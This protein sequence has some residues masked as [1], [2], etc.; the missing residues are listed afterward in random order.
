MRL[1][2]VGFADGEDLFDVMGAM[3]EVEAAPLGDGEGS[4][5]HVIDGTGA[6]AEERLG[7]VA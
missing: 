7:L 1:D 2:L 5:D 6:G 3:G 4:E